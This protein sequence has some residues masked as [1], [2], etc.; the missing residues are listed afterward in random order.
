MP[1]YLVTLLTYQ[2][3]VVEADNEDQARDIAFGGSEPSDWDDAVDGDVYVEEYDG[4]KL[5]FNQ[6]E[7]VK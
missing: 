3:I 2:D 1:K 5:A 4:H 6:K 7:E